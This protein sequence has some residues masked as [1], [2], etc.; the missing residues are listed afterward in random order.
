MFSFDHLHDFLDRIPI[1]KMGRDA[2]DTKRTNRRLGAFEN[3]CPDGLYCPIRRTRIRNWKS[4]WKTRR[5]DRRD[6]G[7][8]G[9][10]LSWDR[11]C[12]WHCTSLHALI[13]MVI[14]RHVA[15]AWKR[16]FR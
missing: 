14:C 15:M 8:G 11:A 7:L 3:I 5:S 16:S 12:V 13:D 6:R 10:A 1:Q 2:I 9:V 4:D